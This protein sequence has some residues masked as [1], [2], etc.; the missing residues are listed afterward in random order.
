MM[1]ALKPDRGRLNAYLDCPMEAFGFFCRMD[2]VLERT[3][4]LVLCFL[5]GDGDLIEDG[6]SDLAKFWPMGTC[7][8]RI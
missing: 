3:S 2:V 7:R 5:I 1:Q 4:L 8:L 6:A